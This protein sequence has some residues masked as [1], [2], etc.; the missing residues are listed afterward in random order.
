M[1]MLL[2]VLGIVY[3]A[4]FIW[5]TVRIVNQPTQWR[6]AGRTAF[7]WLAPLIVVPCLLSYDPVPRRAS[8]RSR[9]KNNLKQIGLALHN[10]SDKYGSLSPA[11]TDGAHR[12]HMHSWRVLILPFLDQAPLYNQYRFDEPWDGPNNRKLAGT[13]LEVFNCPSD[14]H[15]GTGASST[16]TNYVAIV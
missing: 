16:M 3:G 7:F 9:C 5:L 13:I 6:R 11:H 15:G 8:L 2:P 10:Y 1:E 4:L 12:R 14:D